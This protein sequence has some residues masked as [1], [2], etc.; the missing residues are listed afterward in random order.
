MKTLKTVTLHLSTERLDNI[1]GNLYVRR[2]SLENFLDS[3]E[4]VCTPVRDIM[5]SQLKELCDAI[6]ILESY[7]RKNY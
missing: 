4:A 1:L 7:N 3:P 2:K 5:S 6:E